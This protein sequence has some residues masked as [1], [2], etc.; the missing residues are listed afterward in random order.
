MLAGNPNTGAQRYIFLLFD[1]QGRPA[2]VVKAGAGDAAQRL[3]EQEHVFLKA[4]PPNMRAVPVMR[5]AF[6]SE[7]VHAFATDFYPGDSPRGSQ[8][9]QVEQL[10][11][12]WIHRERS[13]RL[14]ALASWQELLAVAAEHL[15]ENVK[16][17]ASTTISPAIFHGDFAPW[18]IKVSQGKW[19]AL[20]WERGQLEGLPL[21]DWLHFVV[22]PAV[23]VRRS[24]P[25]A[26]LKQMEDL[27]ASTPFVR[28][29]TLARTVGLEKP[30]ALAYLHHCIHILRQTEGLPTIK[31]LTQL[32]SE[33]W[34]ST[35]LPI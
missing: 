27:I 19:T 33:K 28:Y 30:L 5:S 24:T 10:L 14:G 21:W 26:I 29:S 20:D 3:I 34:Q 13:A 6:E 17:L 23:L 18:N 9:L 4:V 1:L 8:S 11:T 2:A 22:Q 35:R 12:S 32:A 25:E 31:S 15:P 16:Q 7:N